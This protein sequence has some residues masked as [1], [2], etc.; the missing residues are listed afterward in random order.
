[1]CGLCHNS[2]RIQCVGSVFSFALILIFR[3]LVSCV[4]KI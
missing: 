2:I 3:L 1:M 4:D